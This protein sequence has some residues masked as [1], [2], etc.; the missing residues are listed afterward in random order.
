MD[1][2]R[3]NVSHSTLFVFW[4]AELNSWMLRCWLALWGVWTVDS[5]SL[6]TLVLGLKSGT[7]WSVLDGSKR[8]IVCSVLLQAWFVFLRF[9]MVQ[10]KAKILSHSLVHSLVQFHRSLSHFL[11]LARFACALRS[12]IH[13]LAHSVAPELEGKWMIRSLDAGTTGC[14][15]PYGASPIDGVESFGERASQKL[16]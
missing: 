6:M 10:N 12:F 11:H 7:Q 9:T 13:S 4:C 16:P 5:I 3:K 15:E 1:S 8:L 14:S 2:A